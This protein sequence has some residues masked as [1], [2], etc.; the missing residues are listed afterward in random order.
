MRKF[1]LICLLGIATFSNVLAQEDWKKIESEKSKIS[2]SIPDQPIIQNKELNNISIEVFSFKDAVTVFGVV[3]SD[4]SKLGLD[5]TYSDPSEYYEEMKQ[6]SL[7]SGGS[8]LIGERSVAYQKMLGKEIEYT[9]MVGKHEYTY[10]KRFFF[11]GKYIY[12]IAIGGPSRMK[13]ILLD[14]KNLYFN[15]IDFL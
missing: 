2:F 15:S 3:A 9:Q 13:R 10:F 8:I 7:V 6:G 1:L 4:F 11:R 14:K 12:Q 5:F